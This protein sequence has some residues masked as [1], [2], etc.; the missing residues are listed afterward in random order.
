MSR[1]RENSELVE[2]LREISG[3]LNS[4]AEQS[5]LWS[6]GRTLKRWTRNSYLY[7]WLTAEP[8]P[9]VI[10]IDLRETYTVGP[11]LAAMDR[12]GRY[13]SNTRAGQ[14]SA[15]A[16]ASLSAEVE[17]RP[18]SVFSIVALVALLVNTVVTLAL[19]GFSKTGLALRLLLVAPLLLGTRSSMTAAELSDTWLWKLLEPPEP[20]ASERESGEEQTGD[21]R[22]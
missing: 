14:A 17:R 13:V 16:L 2:S 19:S 4:I 18:V 3:R 7:R 9:D 21:D 5:R 22:D 15:S 11:I 12:A 8:D 1:A 20:P 6:V 10:V